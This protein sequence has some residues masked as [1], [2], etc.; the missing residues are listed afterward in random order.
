VQ[1]HDRLGRTPLHWAAAAG[2]AS[3]F[4]ELLA[5]RADAQA[6]DGNGQTPR[7]I[8]EAMGWSELLAVLDMRLHRA[9]RPAFTMLIVR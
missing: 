4:A 5:H 7:M 1:T 2:C 8:A 9:K 3:A 6:R